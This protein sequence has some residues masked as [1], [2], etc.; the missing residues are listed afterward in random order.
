MLGFRMFRHAVLMLVGNVGPA[1][2]ISLPPA[3]LFLGFLYLLGQ[4]FGGVEGGMLA[5]GVIFG[6]I[7]GITCF[8]WIA[9]AWHRFVLL[10]EAPAALGQQWHGS[11]I[12]GYFW[13]T[14]RLTLFLIVFLLSLTFFV[15]L[16]VIAVNGGALSLA[17]DNPASWLVNLVASYIWLRF[18]P[19]LPAAAIGER[20][21]FGDAWTQ[22]STFRGAI[23]VTMICMTVFLAVPAVLAQTP[24]GAPLAGFAYFAVAGWVQVMLG[25]SVLTTVYGVACQGRELR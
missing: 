7:L 11:E 24:L 21:A 10:E 4:S 1:L 23:L 5:L 2:R 19:V 25:I 16:V 20:M 13:A 18:S 15:S 22:T 6:L 14:V 8:V 17:P 3:A 12:G 9:V